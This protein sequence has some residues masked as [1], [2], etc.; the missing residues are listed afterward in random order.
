MSAEGGGKAA[1]GGVPLIW[2]VA[3]LISYF[4]MKP[5]ITDSVDRAVGAVGVGLGVFVDR[6]RCVGQRPFG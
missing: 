1:S 2:V 4:D 3:G 6:R 5:E